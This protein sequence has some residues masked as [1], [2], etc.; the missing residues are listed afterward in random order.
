M[1]GLMCLIYIRLRRAMGCQAMNGEPP[2]WPTA[3]EEKHCKVLE[4]DEGDLYVRCCF[5]N[6]LG[7]RLI[8]SDFSWPGEA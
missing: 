1:V 3:M 6:L 4:R 5:F 7:P 8:G 2:P